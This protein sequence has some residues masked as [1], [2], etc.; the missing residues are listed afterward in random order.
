ML[1]ESE[2]KAAVQKCTNEQQLEPLFTTAKVLFHY[3]VIDSG[4]PWSVEF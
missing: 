2:L 4:Q 1:C 3:S